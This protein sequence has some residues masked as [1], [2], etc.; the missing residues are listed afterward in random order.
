MSIS[1]RQNEKIKG[2]PVHD[3]E[4]KISL[5]WQTTPLVL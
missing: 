5:F 3:K 4:L 2:I 1:V